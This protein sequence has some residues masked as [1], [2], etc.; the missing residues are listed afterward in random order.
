VPWNKGSD[1]FFE[2]GR[3]APEDLA[4]KTGG[5]VYSATDAN[6]GR[7]LEERLSEL[8][9]AYVLTFQPSGVKNGDGWHDLKVRVP[10]RRVSIR[11]R[12]GYFSAR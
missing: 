5:I 6:L 11:A 10:S 4:A 12:Q 7:K 1:D 9:S 8:R 2:A 3:Q